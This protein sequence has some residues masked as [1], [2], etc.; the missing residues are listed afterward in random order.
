MVATEERAMERREGERGR[1]HGRRELGGGYRTRGGREIG[2][3]H[4]SREKEI[5]EERGKD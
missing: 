5:Q 4:G 1:R 3:R 2:E